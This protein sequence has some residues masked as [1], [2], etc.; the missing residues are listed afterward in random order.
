VLVPL[1][2]FAIVAGSCRPSATEEPGRSSPVSSDRDL[3][4]VD[5]TEV[6]EVLPRDGIPSIDEPRFVSS[7]EATWLAGREPVVAL[8]IAGDARAYPA[9]I[10]T[11]HEIVNDVVGGEPVAVTYCPLCNSA[12]VF[13]R[14]VDGRVLEFGVSGKLY[15]SALIMYDRQTESLWTHFQGIAYEGPLAGTDLKTVP[16]QMLAFEDW[17]RAYPHGKVLSRRT[18]FDVEYGTNPYA[19]YDTRERPYEHF[20]SEAVDPRLPVMH[21]VVGVPNQNGGVAYAYRDLA[22]ADAGTTVLM[23]PARNLVIFWQAGTASAVDTTD[24]GQGR[25]VGATGVFSPVAGDRMLSLAAADGGFRDRE[26][27]STWS[28][29][30]LALTGPLEGERLRPVEHLDT[31]W[32]AWQAYYPETDLYR[33]R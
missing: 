25:D 6:V 23:D 5:I 14:T 17:R 27:G 16:A 15:R 9:Q 30:G 28:L 7:E 13:Q 10:M 11:R 21:R 20:F 26:T 2:T 31:F 3:P 22:D 4:A 33:A 1:A 32:F 24:I 19:G 18:G 29:S 8:E 12:L